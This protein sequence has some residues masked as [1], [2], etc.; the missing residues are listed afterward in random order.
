M[1]DHKGFDIPEGFYN[2]RF[3]FYFL[4]RSKSG[5]F[6]PHTQGPEVEKVQS[7]IKVQFGYLYRVTDTPKLNQI[8]RRTSEMNVSRRV[9]IRSTQVCCLTPSEL[10][11]RSS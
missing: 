3:F 7:V 8:Q 10:R 9:N 1:K 2:F 4:Q 11:E 6:T 5:D